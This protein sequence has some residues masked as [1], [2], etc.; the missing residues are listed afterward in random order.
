LKLV[1]NLPDVAEYEKTIK[2]ISPNFR[3]TTQNCSYKLP[4]EIDVMGH[5]VST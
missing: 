5:L 4:K 2:T 1:N 3:L